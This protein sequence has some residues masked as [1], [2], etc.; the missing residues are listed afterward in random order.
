TATMLFE[1]E[2][3]LC[4]VSKKGPVRTPEIIKETLESFNLHAGERK[5]CM[6]I[7]VS[8]ISEISRE[9]REYV[10]EVFPKIF[11]AIAMV[12]G[13]AFGKMI[14]NLFFTIK[15]QPYPT[16]MFTNEH[17]AREW[18]RQYL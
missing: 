17:E 9:G 14:A 3:I 15:T 2:G 6:L 16:K 4:V 7:D 12:S 8:E 11:K 1:E 10:A 5:I 13:S 18:L